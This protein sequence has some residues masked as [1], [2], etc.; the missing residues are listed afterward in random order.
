M[1]ISS[2]SSGVASFYLATPA[3]TSNYTI[4]NPNSPAM[5]LANDV[6]PQVPGPFNTQY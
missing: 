3:S 5:Y 2:P 4:F 1:G 6:F